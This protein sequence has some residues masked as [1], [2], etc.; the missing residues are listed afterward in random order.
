MQMQPGNRT[1]SLTCAVAAALFATSALAQEPRARQATPQRTSETTLAEWLV[2]KD[3]RVSELVGKRVINPSGKDLGEVE[4]LL[5]TPG[6]GEQK[7]VVVLSVGGVLDVGDKRYATSLDQLR[8]ADDNAR[9]VLNKTEQ[10]LKDAPEFHYTPTHGEESPLPGVRGPDTTSSIGRLVGATVVDDED[11]SIGEIK[12]FV[13]STGKAGTRAVV[14]LD[15]DAGRGVEG[16]LVTIPID[17]LAIELSAE[18]AR[19]IPQ[20]ARVRVELDGTPVEALPAYEYPK[21]DP[22]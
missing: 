14:G 21:R 20:Q 15:E 4:D 5:A 1:L 22:I 3:A 10:E 9:L 13:V 6:R 16:R 7:P 11:E 17:D 18:E 2:D 12:D 19:A 8:I